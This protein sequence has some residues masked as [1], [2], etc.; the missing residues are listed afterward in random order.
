M[1]ESC[2]SFFFHFVSP[3]SSSCACAWFMFLVFFWFVLLLVVLWFFCFVA[4]GGVAGVKGHDLIVNAIDGCGGSKGSER[5][6]CLH[7]RTAC[8][9]KS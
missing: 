3:S 5:I 8:G 4:S 2:G 9:V 7:F 6:A 1:T